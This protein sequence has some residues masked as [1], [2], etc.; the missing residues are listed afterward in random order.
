MLEKREEHRIEF[1]IEIVNFYV[2]TLWNQNIVL[3]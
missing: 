3:D 2:K 1:L